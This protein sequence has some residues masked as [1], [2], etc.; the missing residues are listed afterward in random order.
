M[1]PKYLLFAFFIVQVLFSQKPRVFLLDADS[2]V[3]IRSSISGGN[4]IYTPALK[5]LL[6]DADKALKAEPLSVTTKVLLPPTGDKH[7][8]Y[9]LSRYWWPDP[10]KPDGKPYIRRDGETNPENETITDHVF[11]QKTVTNINTLALAFY[12][13]GEEKYAERAS[14][15]IRVWFL[16]PETKMNPNLTYSQTILGRPEPRGTGILDAREFCTLVDGLGIL[17]LS[18]SW[19]KKEQQQVIAWFK[20]YLKWLRESK[21]GLHEIDAQNNHGTW[22]DVQATAIALFVGETAIAKQICEG[23]K[24]KRIA[25]QIT[26][27]GGQ[28]E[29]LVRTLSF[30]YSTFNL[31]ALSRLATLSNHVGVDLW[32]YKTSDNRGIRTALDHLIPYAYKEKKWEWPQIKDLDPEYLLLV[33][34]KAG[35]IYSD[36]RYIKVWEQLFDGTKE[37]DKI[38]LQQGFVSSAK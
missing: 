36:G 13:T 23:A 6:K 33:A 3:S 5:K 37:S 10:S 17:Q 14:E 27:E 25:Y 24:S 4:K 28:P 9:S 30:H 2:L 21:N 26:P 22:Y 29:E 31:F 1:R 12:Y 8:Y 15:L 18:R 19:E 35:V 7:D 32:N 16:N 20:E 11:L 38:V 34:R